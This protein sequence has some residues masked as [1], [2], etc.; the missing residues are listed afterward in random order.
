MSAVNSALLWLSVRNHNLLSSVFAVQVLLVQSV[1][2]QVTLPDFIENLS[3]AY[4]RVSTMFTLLWN[5]WQSPIWMKSTRLYQYLLLSAR[6]SKLNTL[7]GDRQLEN[8]CKSA[9]G[10]REKVSYNNSIF[11]PPSYHTCSPFCWKIQRQKLI[12]LLSFG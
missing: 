9:L 4:C 12:W 8:T 3:I 5:C 6:S 11:Q 7:Y 2:C 10:R 1:F